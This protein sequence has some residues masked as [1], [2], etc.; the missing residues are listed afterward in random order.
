[1][2][3]WV[4]WVLDHV[5]GW[6]GPIVICVV[7]VVCVVCV[8][9]CGWCWCMW[10][11]GFCGCMC[12]MGGMGSVCIGVCCVCMDGFVGVCVWVVWVYG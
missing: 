11:Y 6:C 7:L 12:V 8:C 10:V 5:G 9:V 3:V 2:S 1:M 4:L